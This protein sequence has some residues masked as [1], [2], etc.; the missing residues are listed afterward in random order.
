MRNRRNTHNSGRALIVFTREPVPGLTKTR[1]MPY[2]SADECAALHKCF[3]RDIR[4]QLLR[5]DADILVFY[6]GDDPAF[7]RKLWGWKTPMIRQSGE[8]LGERMRRAVDRV[9]GMGYT[10]AVLIGTDLPEMKADCIGKAFDLIGDHD[11]VLG[12]TW[13]G[14]YYLIG[15]RR[16]H[17][18]AFAN[19]SY[20]GADV[21][22]ATVNGLKQAGLSVAL[23][24]PCRDIDVPEDIGS[25][26][27]R[28]RADRRL[29]RSHTGRFLAESAKI[30]VIIPVYNEEKQVRSIMR[31]LG[32]ADGRTEVIFVDG[33]ST[34][35]TAALIEKRF[36]VTVTGKGRG[37]QLNEGAV[38]SSGDIL[39]FL[40]CDSRLPSGFADE[41]R[42]VMA[43]CGWGCFG[44]RF[45]SRNFFMLTNRI[46]SNFRAFCRRIPFGDQGIFIDR[47]LFFE[48]GMFPEIPIMEDYAFSLKL[49]ERGI[50]P[51][52]TRRRITTSIR[53]YG[54]G[55]QGILK[56][57]WSMYRMRRRFRRGEDVNALAEIYGDIR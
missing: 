38:K 6:E 28:M 48:T 31:Q 35:G 47:E 22:E 12:P 37:R 39:F 11:V 44:V 50:R 9:F 23:T 29:R 46:I 32:T 21:L 14:G 1:L 26:R 4:R 27:R 40:H 8:G 25:Y 18:E 13:D 49:K 3:L 41:I 42:R 57:E 2:M 10:E 24:D 56:T 54:E 43:R 53:R 51:G 15:M 17:P 36:P 19:H 55:T 30:S 20:G 34:D 5:T 52:V 33:G 45:P 16:M 7:L